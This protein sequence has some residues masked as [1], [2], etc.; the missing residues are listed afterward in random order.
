MNVV[1]LVKYL[2]ATFA[3]KNISISIAMLNG[4]LIHIENIIQPQKVRK[5]K[6]LIQAIQQNQHQQI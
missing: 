5:V 4:D 1:I 2:F 6:T 3:H